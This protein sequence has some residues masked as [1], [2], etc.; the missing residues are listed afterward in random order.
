VYKNLVW[1]LI[2]NCVV[3]L[4]YVPSVKGLGVLLDC[5]LYFHYHIYYIFSQGLKMF[6]FYFKILPRNLPGVTEG[7]HR[8][9][10]SGYS[11]PWSRFKLGIFRIQ[12][13]IVTSWVNL[14]AWLDIRGII[15]SY[16]IARSP[17][18][19]NTEL[20]LYLCCINNYFFLLGPLSRRQQHCVLTGFSLWRNYY[21]YAICIT[22]NNAL[23]TKVAQMHL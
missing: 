1:T 4:F 19:W 13:K 3:I 21:M 23:S 7:N 12:V 14:L 10:Q 20:N 22:W 11:V 15:S 6:G 9:P 17:S 16:M 8:S 5:K 2:I 18:S